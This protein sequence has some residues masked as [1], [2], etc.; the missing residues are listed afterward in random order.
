MSSRFGFAAD[1][2]DELP[3]LEKTEDG[4]YKAGAKAEVKPKFDPLTDRRMWHTDLKYFGETIRHGTPDEE[5]GFPETNYIFAAVG[6]KTRDNILETVKRKS[7]GLLW[8]EEL[9][10]HDLR[11]MLE[12]P[13]LKKSG[14]KKVLTP[15]TSED[16]NYGVWGNNN[17]LVTFSPFDLASKD[18]KEGMS[19]LLLAVHAIGSYYKA[20]FAPQGKWRHDFIQ[21]KDIDISTKKGLEKFYEEMPKIAAP[22]IVASYEDEKRVGPVER[23]IQLLGRDYRLLNS[24]AATEGFVEINWP[25]AKLWRIATHELD[26]LENFVHKPYTRNERDKQEE[27]NI[28]DPVYW[29][30]AT[31]QSIENLNSTTALRMRQIDESFREA[32]GL[33][34]RG[35]VVKKPVS[36]SGSKSEGK[37][38]PP[39]RRVVKNR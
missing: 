1:S 27:Q 22:Q 35:V 6:S 18:V 32:H 3:S 34:R 12:S 21:H 30:R 14:L 4:T 15:F 17:V 26:T 24:L 31:Q 33:T 9:T 23:F 25:D 7:R 20:Q 10:S 2:I 11:K 37:D 8:Y 5:F 28:K 16:I 39:T 38:K 29:A 36:A 19:D 13:E